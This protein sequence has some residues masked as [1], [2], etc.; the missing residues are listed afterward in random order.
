MSSDQT[1]PVEPDVAEIIEIRD[2]EVDVEA[3]MARVRE[4]VALR[5]AQGAYQEDLD[6]IAQQVLTSVLEPMSAASVAEKAKDPLEAALAELNAR[7]MVREM[8]FTSRA[9]VIG[10]LIVAVRNFWN[11]M[12]TKWYVLAIVQQIVA[13]H[14]AVI[15]AFSEL[16]SAQRALDAEVRQLKALSEQQQATIA[17]LQEELRRLRSSDLP[18]RK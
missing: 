13:F 1:A 2:P 9:P 12:S 16:A 6:A 17:G 18:S 7:C 4:N 5:R 8:P 3:I 15:T 14:I 11:W 10:P